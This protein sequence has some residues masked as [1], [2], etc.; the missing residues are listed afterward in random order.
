MVRS[1]C[2]KTS[3]TRTRSAGRRCRGG[4]GNR[5]FLT[6]IETCRVGSMG[7][8]RANNKHLPRRVYFK[9]GRYWFVDCDGK[10]H[11]LGRTEGDMYRELGKFADRRQASLTTMSAVFDRYLLERLPLL[12]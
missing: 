12:A 6:S 1:L 5:T 4:I 9:H 3:L 10:W 7:R 11:N 8:R 2:A